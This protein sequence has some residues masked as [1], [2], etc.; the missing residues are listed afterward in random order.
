MRKIG[1]S[2]RTCFITLFR[3]CYLKVPAP[4]SEILQVFLFRWVICSQNTLL[5]LSAYLKTQT[6]RK[7]QNS[8]SQANILFTQRIKEK[9]QLRLAKYL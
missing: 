3:K 2:N 7:A 5:K 9:S 1:N 4:A 6:K 8:Y